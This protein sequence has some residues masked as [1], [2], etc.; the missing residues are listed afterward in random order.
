MLTNTLK[1]GDYIVVLRP[2]N[3]LTTLGQYTGYND[4]VCWKHLFTPS[5]N[6]AQGGA[7]IERERIDVISDPNGT[8]GWLGRNYVNQT[9]VALYGPTPLVAAMR[10]LVASRLGDEVEIP[11]ELCK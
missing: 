8:A 7:L 10:C 1:Y 2:N 11:D 5:T 9:I 6:W 3:R 4:G